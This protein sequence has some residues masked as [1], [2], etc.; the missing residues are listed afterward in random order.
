M[1]RSHRPLL[2]LAGLFTF[3]FPVA[4]FLGLLISTDRSWK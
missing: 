2:W 3:L 1:P 4:G